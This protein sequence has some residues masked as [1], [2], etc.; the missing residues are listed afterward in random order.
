MKT[1]RKTVMEFD[2]TQKSIGGDV[3]TLDISEDDFYEAVEVSKII[4]G[5]EK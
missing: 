4:R 2:G 3:Q 1:R 5:H